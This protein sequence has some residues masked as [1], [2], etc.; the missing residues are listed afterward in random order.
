MIPHEHKEEVIQSGISFL[1]SITLA[2][3]S[4]TGMELWDTISTTLDPDVKGAIFFAML[5]GESGSRITVRD[6]E[7]NNTNKVSIIKAI[8]EVTGLGLKE[9]KDMSDILM[10]GGYNGS[11]S[12]SGSAS[13]SLGKSI[14]LEIGRNKNRNACVA[15]LR[16][17][18]CVI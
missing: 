14:T 15:I 6:Y 7:R 17:A 4:E 16:N 9:A 12:Y 13:Y 2:F 5:T 3:G 10:I 11:T 1:R 8:R 18:G